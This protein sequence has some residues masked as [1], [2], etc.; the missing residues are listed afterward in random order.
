[1][2]MFEQCKKAD[3]LEKSGSLLCRARVSVGHTGEILMVISRTV[4]YRPNAAYYVIFYDPTMGLVTCKCRLSSSFYL[5]D[6]SVCALR[7]QVLD[8]LAQDQRRQDM[9]IPVQINVMIHTSSQPSDPV[10]VSQLGFPASIINISAG[11][12][13]LRTALPLPVGR[14]VWF[15]LRQTGEEITL[16]AEILRM[17]NASVRPGQVLYGYGC[18]FVNLLSR[19]E[20]LLRSYVFQEE[21]EMRQQKRG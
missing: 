3:I 19:H 18:R 17:E 12:V 11:G 7:C 16:S 5:S 20:A 4:V 6:P 9:K 15:T 2:P 13:Y 10:R 14:R 21:R 1:M 8:R